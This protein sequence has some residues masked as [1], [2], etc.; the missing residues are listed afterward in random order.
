MNCE[1]FNDR[2]PE[3]LDEALSAAEKADASE[4]V[5]KCGDCRRALA[6]HEAFAKSLRLSFNRETQGLSLRPETRRN[7]FSALEPRGVL[8][9]AWAYIRPFIEII[10]R[11]PAW[12]GAFL[13]CLL[14]LISG[15]IFYR[16][17]MKNTV[18]GERNNYVINVPLQTEIY[19]YRRQNNLVVDAV[20]TG[21]SIA[22]ASFSENVRPST[23]SRP[24]VN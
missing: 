15:S 18:K 12:T 19:V 17:P 8:L 3:Y 7:I 13:L 23:S 5:Q 9:T 20:V 2:L 16:H 22:D 1:N 11:Q 10:W 6:R 4:H 21:T 14:L 24:H